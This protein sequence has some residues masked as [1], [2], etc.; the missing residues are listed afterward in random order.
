MNVQSPQFLTDLYGDLRDRR[1]LPLVV[2]LVVGFAVVPMAL[3]SKSKPPAPAIAGPVAPAA[4]KS[5]LPAAQVVINNPGLR[6]FKQRLKGDTP[7]DPFVQRFGSA[8]SASNGASS[9][10]GV[11]SSGG[12]LVQT[13]GST[14]NPPLT[15]EGQ[16]AKA[17]DTGSGPPAAPGSGSSGSPSSSSPSGS[18]TGAS[19]PTTTVTHKYYSYRAKLRSG[20]VGGDMKVRDNA[21][22]VIPLPSKN[23]PAVAFLG[24]NTNSQFQGQTAV[25]LVNSAVTLVSGNGTCTL[26]GNQCQV[27]ALEPGEHADFT[28]TDGNTY[29]VTLVK[30]ILVTRNKPPAGIANPNGDGNSGGNGRKASAHGKSSWH[31][32]TGQHFTF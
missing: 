12:G 7:I 20:P 4:Q 1:L 14:A 25:F 9:T 6:D 11:V 10:G 18:P 5:N 3:S 24:V 2:V 27:V 15:A 17:A 31:S 23:V 8:D 21:M 19:A 30:F 16:A 29:R 13:A 28:W 26:V 32:P 22:G